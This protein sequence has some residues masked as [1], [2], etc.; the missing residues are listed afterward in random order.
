MTEKITT[1]GLN[2]AMLGRQLLLRREPLGVVDAVCR[3]VALQAQQPASPY[4]ALWNR[5][6]DFDPAELDTAF[7]AHEVVKA[8]LMRVTLHAVHIDDYR[9][10]RE[11]MEPTLRGARLYDKRY[12]AS[13]LT[14]ADAHA[15]IPGLLEYAVRPRTAAEMEA[16]VEHQLGESKSGAWWGLRQYAPLWHAPAGPP[17]SFGQRTSFIAASSR[18]VLGDPSDSE[19]LMRGEPAAGLQRLMRRYLEGFGP[20]SVADWA[21]FMMIRRPLV[22]AALQGLAGELEQLKGPDGTTLYDI[23]GALLPSDDTPAPPRLMAMWDSV[24]LAH[25]DRGRIIPPAYR[26]LVTRSNGDVLPTLLIDGY[27]AGVWRPTEGGIEAT[28]FHSLPDDVWKELAA[29]ARSLVAFL[30][31]REP[32]VYSRYGYWWRSLP[33]DVEVRLLPGE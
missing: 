3:V 21:Q 13:G 30:A 22:K 32:K 12:R 4:I 26:K 11:G 14:V 25:A 19:S 18:P 31:G 2:R 8:T 23:P 33:D 9:A 28:A 1:R 15:L 6:H 5:L 10:L 16:R 27:V 24:L 7:A 17:W 29:E 20:A